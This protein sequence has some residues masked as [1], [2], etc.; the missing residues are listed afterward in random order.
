MFSRILIPLD[1]SRTAEA[2]LPYARAL[3]ESLK[4]PLEF[5]G[6][7]DI[8]GAAARAIAGKARYLGTLIEEGE[9]ANEDYLHRVA[10]KTASLESRCSVERG[11]PAEVIVRHAGGDQGVL[12]AMASHGRTGLSRWLL[13]SVA[14]KVLRTASNP[15]LLVRA[16]DDAAEPSQV[17]LKSIIVPLDGSMLAESVLPAAAAFAGCFD[18]EV[19]LF[20]AYELPASAY[21]GKED[22]LPDYE[23]M[24]DEIREGAQNYLEAKAQALKSRGLTRVRTA[25][26]EGPG[27][28]EVLRIARAHAD[29]LV[30]MCTHGRSGVK[31][32]LIGSVTE[33]V[34]RHSENPM[35]VIRG[36]QAG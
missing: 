35:L 22:H 13:G 25:L 5:L 18:V 29:S 14:E 3:A 12:I 36:A 6:V 27:A 26:A 33:K 32:W 34:V 7:V 19:V 11:K 15:L 2:A 8:S 1:G 17:S 4:I 28:Q 16:V 30:A 20:R 31:R 24:K 23:A 21:Y 9:R 10:A